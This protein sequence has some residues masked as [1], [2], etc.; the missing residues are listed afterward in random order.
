MLLRSM[1]QRL[2]P[3]L[4]LTTVFWLVVG[5]GPA[6]FYGTTTAKREAHA[7]IRAGEP[8]LDFLLTEMEYNRYS[9]PGNELLI[10]GVLHDIVS[11]QKVG[12]RIHIRA[13]RDDR[14]TFVAKRL[15][16][17][18]QRR[19]QQDRDFPQLAG[20]F[21]AMKYLVPCLADWTVPS[22]LQFSPNQTPYGPIVSSRSQW[23]EEQPPA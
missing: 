17:M 2:G 4:V 9:V 21:F 8:L 14:E 12:D 19:P 18:F 1:L 11:C 13:F 10:D 15:R 23:V 3:F 22:A 16:K 7:R 20:S 6:L 5:Q